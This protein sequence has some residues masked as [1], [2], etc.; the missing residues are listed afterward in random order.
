V[1]ASVFIVGSW[2]APP[3]LL[4]WCAVGFFTGMGM[5]FQGFRLLQR[6]RLILDTPFSKIRSA[7]MG[8]VEVSGLAVGPYNLISPITARPCYFYRALVWEWKKSGRD[9]RWVRSASECMHVPFFLDDNSGRVLVDPRG[10]EIDLH[11]DFYQEFNNSFFSNQNDAPTNVNDFLLRAGVVTSNKIR[12]EEYC[13]KPKNS[14][15]ILGTLAENPGIEVTPQ[16]VRDQEVSDDSI[17]VNGMS[18]AQGS[19]SFK[20][21]APE[22]HLEALFSHPSASSSAL[23]LQTIGAAA[24]AGAAPGA[25]SQQQKIATALL[26]AGISNPAAWTAAWSAASVATPGGVQ[27]IEDSSAA[28]TSQATVSSDAG[29]STHN[30]GF[31]PRPAVVLT[32]GTNNKTFLISWRGQQEVAR[33]LGWKCLVFIWSGPP[34]ALISLYLF[35]AFEGWLGAP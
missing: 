23:R 22:E 19:S 13:I 33:S 35:L 7:P 1:I 10:A 16:P 4:I 25:R 9:K 15:F 31:E 12:V 27:V 32:R 14:L 21:V 2:S 8:L 30:G 28:N 11:R 18:I 24:A 29:S 3:S 20:T 26:K 34:L 17:S 6:R 5:F